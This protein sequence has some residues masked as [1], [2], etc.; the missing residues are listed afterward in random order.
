MAGNRRW[1]R[2]E[3][4]AL[5]DA[6]D[7]NVDLKR[8]ARDLSRTVDAVYLRAHKLGL[9]RGLPEGCESLAA[10]AKRT[11]YTRA[12]LSCILK[13][14]GHP[15]RKVP[16][17]RPCKARYRTLFVDPLDV[18][19]AIAAWVRAEA[20]EAAARRL[21]LCAN[22]LRRWIGKAGLEDPRR[23]GRRHLRLTDEQIQ[24]ALELRSAAAKQRAEKAAHKLLADR[25]AGVLQVAHD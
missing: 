6:W 12:Q 8:I 1:K 9:K 13:M 20:V 7:R 15:P 14:A 16:H 19:D 4:L 2:N 11:G 17:S 22:T 25:Q 18:D 23:K 5:V 3:D 10:A 24:R 21:G